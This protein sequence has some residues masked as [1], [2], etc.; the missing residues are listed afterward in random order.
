ML[1]WLVPY[2]APYLTLIWYFNQDNQLYT[3]FYSITY[4]IRDMIY[5][6]IYA[7]NF[8]SYYNARRLKQMTK[9][10]LQRQ[11]KPYKSVVNFK[12][13][14]N[15]TIFEFIHFK[16]LVFIYDFNFIVFRFNFFDWFLAYYFMILLIFYYSYAIKLLKTAL[17]I[18]E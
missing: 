7:L 3:A 10:G 14:A 2:L 18:A 12:V 13:N 8:I 5:L 15:W 4:L 6:Q 17:K 1:F 9:V 11:S 16:L